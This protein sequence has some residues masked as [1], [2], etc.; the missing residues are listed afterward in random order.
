MNYPKLSR[1]P[2][3][4]PRNALKVSTEASVNN[5]PITPIE[6]SKK[7]LR[8]HPKIPSNLHRSPLK[9]LRKALQSSRKKI[10]KR[11]QKIKIGVLKRLKTSKIEKKLRVFEGI[12]GAF[13]ELPGHLFSVLSGSS[14]KSLHR[15]I[16]W[17]TFPKV[18]HTH[19]PQP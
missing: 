9:A 8:N 2:L 10:L 12:P 13:P 11:G 5:C 18:N 15:G 4:Y 17:S 1:K 3:K 14:K 6:V 16:S 19:A 7:Y